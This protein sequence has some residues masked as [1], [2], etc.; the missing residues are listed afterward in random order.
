MTTYNTGYPLS[1]VL[2]KPPVM[3]PPYYKG[4]RIRVAYFKHTPPAVATAGDGDVVNLG[5]L[6][7][8][9]MVIA[10]LQ[11]WGDLNDGAHTAQLRAGTTALSAANNVGTAQAAYAFDYTGVGVLIDTAAEETV[12]LLLSGAAFNEASGSETYEA[13]VLYAQ[14]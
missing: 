13:I 6:P 10:V 1:E 14:D 12:N 7:Q 4:G 3:V 9:S 5:S 2:S 11:K 8:G